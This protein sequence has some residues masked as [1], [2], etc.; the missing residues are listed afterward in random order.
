M[1]AFVLVA[2]AVFLTATAPGSASVVSIGGGLARACYLAAEAHNSNAT[3][4]R[5]CDL[6]LTHQ[7]LLADDI[8]ATHVNRGIL[9]MLGGN[10]AGAEADFKQALA[11]DPDEAEAWL[12]YGILRLNQKNSAAAIEMF[13]R[14]LA[15]Q[16]RR[17]AL[18][19]LARGLANED[20]GDVRA[21]YAD[22]KRAQ[23]LAPKW[24]LPAEELSRYQVR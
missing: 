13:E 10:K 14:A 5:E 11:L 2:G 9:R 17:P 8:V 1:K 19:Y 18:A 6:A 16:T 7:P 24:A 12:N 20:R 22:L 3:T 15:L 4:L 21:A 23:S